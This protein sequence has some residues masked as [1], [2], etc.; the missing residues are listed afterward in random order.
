M[1]C[2]SID[3][4]EKIRESPTKFSRD[5]LIAT[6]HV[7]LRHKPEAKRAIQSIPMAHAAVRPDSSKQRVSRTTE[8]ISIDASLPLSASSVEGQR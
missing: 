6:R 2:F 7:V 3:V 8:Y 1:E 4:I 5:W